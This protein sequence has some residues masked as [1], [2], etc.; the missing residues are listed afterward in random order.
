MAC[1]REFVRA[2]FR[3][4]EGNEPLSIEELAAYN[5][6]RAAEMARAEARRHSAPE[7]ELP[8]EGAA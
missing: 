4:V 2:L 3:K 6:Q 8:L 5:S 1:N 7:P